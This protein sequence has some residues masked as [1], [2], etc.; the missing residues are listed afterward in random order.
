MVF[1]YYLNLRKNLISNLIIPIKR[2]KKKWNFC[3]FYVLLVVK[4]MTLAANKL[5]AMSVTL[6]VCI[7][8]L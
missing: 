8:S 1:N 5:P 3:F 2:K 4:L 7:L 6:P